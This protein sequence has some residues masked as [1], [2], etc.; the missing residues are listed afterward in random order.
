[1][2]AIV[3]HAI[4]RRNRSDQIRGESI[5]VS[6]TQ[7][8]QRRRSPTERA[9]EVQRTAQEL[10]LA[11]GLS[12]LTLRGIGQRMHVASSLVA[13]Y[14]PSMDRLVASTFRILADRE[15]D[16]V[17]ALIEAAQDPVDE[18]R[19]LLDT[20]AEPDRD[21]VAALW[22]D[23]WSLGRRNE[24]LAT[25]ARD[26]MGRWQELATTIVR[27]GIETGEFHTD[28]VDGV[29]VLLFALVD[30]T[31]AYSLVDYR[32]PSERNRLIRRAMCRALALP[33]DRLD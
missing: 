6:T 11:D 13:H 17:T 16:E 26:C 19:A 15:I 28:D 31:N 18:L 5:I 25:A 21:D 30:A 9:A 3:D 32:Q 10:A 29:G 24:D 14:E 12:A 8:R 27:R 23:A 20:V 1:M 33:P 4:N 2:R 22:S 7:P